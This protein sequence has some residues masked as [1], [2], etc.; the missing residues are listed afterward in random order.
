MKKT[1]LFLFMFVS[2]LRCGMA[3]TQE[4]LTALKEAS[5]VFQSKYYKSHVWDVQRSPAIPVAGEEWKLRNFDRPYDASNS[6]EIDWG[7]SDDRYLMFDIELAAT[8]SNS[9]DLFGSDNRYN[10]VLRLYEADGTY[11]KDLCSYGN[12]MGFGDKGFLFN[13]TNHYG[14]FFANDNY[15]LGA[16]LTY[17]PTTGV[18]TRLSELK[19]YQYSPQLIPP[20]PGFLSVLVYNGTLQSIPL[21]PN[22]A[23]SLTGDLRAARVGTY[24]A[25]AVLND[26]EN[27]SWSDG[28]TKDV[29]VAWRIVKAD[30][31]MSAVAWDYT[32]PFV[33]DGTTKTVS[34][35]GLPEGVSVGRYDNN[36]ATEEGRYM[37]GAVLVYDFSNYNEVS[38]PGLNWTINRLLIDR[39]VPT[40]TSFV[41]NGEVQGI[42]LPPSEHYTVSGTT[43]STDPGNYMAFVV[44]SNSRNM[45][46]TDGG[47]GSDIINWTIKKADYDMSA[48]VWDYTEPF[49]YDG[50][51]K[52]VSLTGLPEGVSVNSYK[53]NTATDVGTYSASAVLNYQWW[54]YNKPEVPELNWSIENLA[55]SLGQA[56][57]AEAVATAYP[58]PLMA[59]TVLQVEI[60]E[61][62]GANANAELL[63]LSGL[64][65]PVTIEKQ[66]GAYRISGLT[67]PGVYFV[68]IFTPTKSIAVL[69]VIVK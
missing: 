33:W 7:E 51:T 20:P 67:R 68:R 45:G 50:T 2:I 60:G 15:E 36:T 1:L 9:D 6:R 16:L 3:Q 17:T 46:W 29:Y 32:E 37:A 22:A 31:D 10:V 58:N 43:S 53:G 55:L 4:E 13:Q 19:S 69:K 63:N 42:T 27:T 59:G 64:Q 30:Y 21:S 35:T 25:Y 56:Q 62:H 11:V 5:P 38:V 26:K 18:L 24:S 65:V 40:A 49:I 48:V 12:F 8:G 57:N 66:S 39:P 54:N 41:Y 61:E 23:Y 28:T 47:F 14:T 34:L 44:L 52:T